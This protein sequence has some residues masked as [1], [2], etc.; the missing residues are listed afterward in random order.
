MMK[1]QRWASQCM[2][3]FRIKERKYENMGQAP[4]MPNAVTEFASHPPENRCVFRNRNSFQHRAGSWLAIFSRECVLL[5]FD[6]QVHMEH[7]GKNNGRS[8][9]GR[10]GHGLDPNQGR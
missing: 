2:F 4:I 10:P 9:I 6:L 3:I 5:G 7:I 1:E 8:T